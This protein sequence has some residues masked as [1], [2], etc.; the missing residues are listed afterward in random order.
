MVH[1]ATAELIESGAISHD[2]TVGDI[3][4]VSSLT[5]PSNVVNS[6]DLLRR[7]ALILISTAE[8]STAEYVRALQYG[9]AGTRSGQAVSKSTAH[10]CY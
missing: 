9:A 3:A 5:D 8:I 4:P 1:R 2:K 6:A 7:G 10:H